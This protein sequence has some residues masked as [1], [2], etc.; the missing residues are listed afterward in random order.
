[1]EI[2]AAKGFPANKADEMNC[3]CDKRTAKEA[4]II[5]SIKD[6][7]FVVSVYGKSDRPVLYAC[8]TLSEALKYIEAEMTEG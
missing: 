5:M 8:S 7:G 4:L 6:G 3:N 2:Q 1:M